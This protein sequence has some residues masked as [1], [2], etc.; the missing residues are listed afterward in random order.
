MPFLCYQTPT[1]QKE[2]KTTVVVMKW[3]SKSADPDADANVDDALM[4]MPCVVWT[5][6]NQT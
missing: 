4:T 2:T 3:E 1:M 5:T 6:S